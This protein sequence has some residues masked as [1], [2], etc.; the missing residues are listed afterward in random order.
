MFAVPWPNDSFGRARWLNVATG[1]LA[2][3]AGL[4]MAVWLYGPALNPLNVTWL[5]AE[6]DSFQHF[7]GWDMFRRDVWRWPLGAVPTLGSAID[8]SVVFSDSIPLIA[9]PLKLLHEVLPDPFQYVGMVMAVNLALNAAVAAGLALRLQATRPGAL[10]VGLL[11][12]ALPAVTMR[13]PGALGHEALSAHWLIMLGLWLGLECSATR[14]GLWRWMLLL[15]LAVLIHFYLFFMVGVLWAAWCI[16]SGWQLRGRALVRHGG[17]MLATVLVTVGVMLATGYFQFGVKIEGDTGFGLYSAGLLTFFNPGSAGLFFGGTDFHGVSRVVPGWL[18]P[19]QGQYEGFAYAGLGVLTLLGVALGCALLRRGSVTATTRSWPS[20]TVWVLAPLAL[21]FFALGNRW[22]LGPWLYE[23]RYPEFLE[24]ITQY[25]RSSGR[26]AWPL[27]YVA[28]FLSLLALVQ[29][30]PA[31]ALAAVLALC[32]A[33]QWW[34]LAPWHVYVRGNM[35][36]LTFASHSYEPFP[37]LARE[38][39]HE[40]AEGRHRLSYL[41]GDD[42][43]HLKAATWLAARNDL[44]INVAYF[45]RVNQGVLYQAAEPAREAYASQGL[46]RDTLYALTDTTLAGPVCQLPEMRCIAVDNMIFAG[47]ERVDNDS[48]Q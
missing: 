8:S 2:A 43:Y 29:R 18:S 46:S 21:F 27:L 38:D 45:A 4:M 24:P 14:Q 41:P 11:V 30:M 48:E 40:L 16:R 25:L 1:L 47:W 31:R 10:L 32:V 3:V 28:V 13:G 35:Q 5:L 15:N 33:L 9:L 42:M 44:S 17:W 19:L 39:L 12:L 34:D 23:W 22:V 6:G 26:M 7:S 36:T 37:W 20:R